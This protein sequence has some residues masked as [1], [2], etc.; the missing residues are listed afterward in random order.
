MKLQKI[1][2][3]MLASILSAGLVLPAMAMPQI[4][5]V[6]S[7]QVLEGDKIIISGNG[8]NVVDEIQIGATTVEINR[9]R[10]NRRIR[11]PFIVPAGIVAAGAGAQS[12]DVTLVDNDN[13]PS[14]EDVKFTV[15]VIDP[16]DIRD[17]NGLRGRDGNDGTPGTPGLQGPPGQNGTNGTNGTAADISTST[18]SAAFTAG[19]GGQVVTPNVTTFEDALEIALGNANAA[20]AGSTGTALTGFVQGPGG[21]TVA[22]TDSILVGFNKLAGNAA[23]NAT[24]LTNASN[25]ASGT[26]ADARLSANVPLLNAA[27][28]FTMANTIP[29]GSTTAPSINFPSDPN[30]GIFSPGADQLSLTAGGGSRL[31]VNAS[32]VQPQ[33]PIRHIN[34]GTETVPSYSFNSTTNTGLFR[35]NV[36]EIAI[37]AAGEEQLRIVDGTITAQNGAVLTGNGSGL[38]NLDASDLGSGTI[39]D[40]RLSGNVAFENAT[41]TFTANQT[42][43]NGDATTPSITF[44]GN[45]GTLGI[46]RATG[47][48]LGFIA[49]GS[50]SFT[51]RSNGITM[52]AGTIIQ[53]VGGSQTAP[54]Y[55]FTDTDTGMYLRNT[56]E[57]AFTVSGNAGGGDVLRMTQNDITPLQQ[58]ETIDGSAGAP[59]YSFANDND[60]GMF[61]TGAGAVDLVVGGASIISAGAA[62]VTISQPITGNPSFTGVPTFPGGTSL[63]DAT[64]DPVTIAG[65]I[66]GATPFVLDGATDDANVIN[67]TVDNPAGTNSINI[68]DTAG[69]FV[70]ANFE[71]EAISSN[72]LDGNGN[73]F[74]SISNTGTLNTVTN[75]VAGGSL[76]LLFSGATTVTDNETATADVI[77]LDETTGNV[78]AANDTLTLIHDGTK[79]REISRSTL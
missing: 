30:T 56:A 9:Q 6:S 18:V 55:T 2:K 42:F 29:L 44:A 13:P 77:D 3:T 32:A 23:V 54:T 64:D 51:A 36:G 49:G 8:L 11:L 57:I 5:S 48:T 12:F 7:R 69:E 68:P 46:S 28:V 67:I 21:Q 20:A 72:S 79:W 41:N 75:G 25:L 76:T 35:P 45:P 53:N 16:E 24:N 73:T 1:F 66:Q 78:F 22:A 26:V 10:N 74:I 38:T 14:Q 15:V 60:T 43:A 31:T 52:S 33:A 37:T 27:N 70:V 17:A 61:R 4:E 40:A 71:S 39:P 58:I 19:P 34:S 62:A 59:S 65:A 47:N 63:G 50:Q